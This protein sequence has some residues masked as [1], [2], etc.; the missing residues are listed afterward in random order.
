M[1]YCASMRGTPVPKRPRAVVVLY[2]A[3]TRTGELSV[4]TMF[5]ARYVTCEDDVG[6][7]AEAGLFRAIWPACLQP[8]MYIM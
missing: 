3:V 2:A 4:M 1:G 5:A 8:I 6:W 7:A